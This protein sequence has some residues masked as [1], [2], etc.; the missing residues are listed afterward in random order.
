MP[1]YGIDLVDEDDARRV[2]LPLL[3]QIADAARAD[4][5]EH[6]DE[7]GAR[8]R[9]ER[10]AGFAG[11]RAREQRLSRARWADEQTALRQTA[12]ELGELLR[13]LQELDDLLQLLLRLVGAGHVGERHLRRVTS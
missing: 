5:H 10:T 7:V 9:E 6:L 12:P 4:A 13:I 3:E 2:R 11:H 1:P 8:H